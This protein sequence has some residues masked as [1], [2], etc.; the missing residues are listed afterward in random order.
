MKQYI[1]IIGPLFLWAI[2]LFL[3]IATITDDI[4]KRVD[5]IK[6][7]QLQKKPRSFPDAW[8]NIKDAFS[9][10]WQDDT[11]YKPTNFTS[12]TTCYNQRNTLATTILSEME[13]TKYPSQMCNCVSNVVKGIKDPTTSTGKNLEGKKDSTLYALESCRWLM[14]NA[15]T[16]VSTGK[17]WA[18]KTAI[19]LLITTLVTGN[20]FDWVIMNYLLK[21]QQ[22]E[23]S[24]AA[25]KMFV[26]FLWSVVGLVISVVSDNNSYMLF[27]LVLIPPIIIL[28]LYESY[29][30]SAFFIQHKP[31]IHP[32]YFTCILG[33]LTL[34]SH[35]EAGILD[36]DV[37]MFE[38]IK[39]NIA[40]YIYLQVIWKYMLESATKSPHLQQYDSKFVEDATL[41]AVIAVAILY[42][43]GLMAP[44][45]K[46]S[47]DSLIWYTPIT[48]IFLTFT[49]ITWICA[50]HFNDNPSEPP[51][52]VP[53][54]NNN[55]E[56]EYEIK[57]AN[58]YVSAIQMLFVFILVLYYLREHSTVYRVLIDKFPPNS[59][60][61]NTS[62]LWQRAPALQ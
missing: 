13:C 6:T 3:F 26:I 11:C 22:A 53:Y 24:K 47:T 38:I 37:I 17:I 29:I 54:K 18:Q 45:A 23:M 8:Y 50:Y 31:F 16:A 51:S 5:S 7:Y 55:K 40:G 58:K 34:L 49:S 1:H 56:P 33:A 15:H 59:I 12:D 9:S 39:C 46:Y 62:S 20:A 52:S 60:Q 43:V 4:P 36:F 42:M 28:A 57:A 14:H 35:A 21:D 61:Y 27:S 41:R 44:Y 2:A 19:V 10:Y 32:Y 48:W 25:I 30:T